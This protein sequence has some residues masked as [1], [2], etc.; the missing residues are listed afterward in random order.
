MSGIQNIAV[1][2]GGSWGTA[3]AHILSQAGRDVTLY[4]RDAGLADKINNTHENPVYLAGAKLHDRLRATASLETALQKA[5]LCLLV[6]PTQYLRETLKKLQPHLPA[7][8]PLVNASKGIEMTTGYLLSEVA[9]ELLPG[10]PYAAFSGP[11]FATEAVRG[12]PTA[13]TLA[14]SADEKTAQGWANALRGRTFRPYLSDD[15]IGVEIAGALKNVIAI[16]CGIVEGRGLGQNAK[17]AVMTRGIAEI[18]RL[19][20]KR[21]AKPETFLGLAGLGDLTLTCSSMTSRN[22][23]LGFELG[24]GKPLQQILAERKSVS[25]GVTTSWAVADYAEQHG[26][27][28]PICLAVRHVLHNGANVDEIVQGLLS[29]DLKNENH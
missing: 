14:T 16:A 8:I 10:H 29:R 1:I 11:T 23:S 17:A 7:G 27:D 5:Q 21:G 3:L 2:G 28:M 19:G 15:V 18:R 4:A 9:A 20:V 26:V 22:Y 12:L 6:T 24:Q 25:E 13:I